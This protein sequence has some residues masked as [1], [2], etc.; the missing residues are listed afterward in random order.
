MVSLLAELQKP[1][2]RKKAGLNYLQKLVEVVAFCP[3][4][5]NMET[6]LFSGN[7]LAGERRYTQRSGYV[8]H[9]CGSQKPCR[10]YGPR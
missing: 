10:L 2:T 4:C 5:K 7:E 8:F 9:D 6:L 1:S 3:S